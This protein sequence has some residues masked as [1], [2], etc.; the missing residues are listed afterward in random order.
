MGAADLGAGFAV[1][2]TN[3]V[4]GDSGTESLDPSDMSERCWEGRLAKAGGGGARN[5]DLGGK[6]EG[7]DDS[8]AAAMSSLTGETVDVGGDV[9]PGLGLVPAVAICSSLV[10]DEPSFRGGEVETGGSKLKGRR[11]VFDTGEITGK[12][13]GGS[14]IPTIFSCRISSVLFGVGVDPG[15]MVVGAGS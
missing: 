15:V 4:V 3:G 7:W 9:D 1:R 5:A 6:G 10:L 14:T 13:L 2:G 12:L 8:A 11:G